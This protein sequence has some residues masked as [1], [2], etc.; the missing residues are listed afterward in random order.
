MSELL[1]LTVAQA[2][3]RI[4]S[5]ELSA[6]EYFDASRVLPQLLDRVGVGA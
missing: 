1:D 5:G 3:E 6:E 4:R 2:A